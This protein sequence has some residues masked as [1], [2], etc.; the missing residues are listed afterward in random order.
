MEISSIF[1]TEGIEKTK[2]E[3]ISMYKSGELSSVKML[4]QFPKLNQAIKESEIIAG[5]NSDRFKE[6]FN[7]V[8]ALAEETENTISNVLDNTNT[9]LSITTR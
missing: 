1:N 2:E 8:A 7:E 5:E 6:F 4:E 3:L 9:S